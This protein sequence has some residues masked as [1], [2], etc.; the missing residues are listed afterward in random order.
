[1][2]RYLC[3][4]LALFTMETQAQL[5]LKNGTIDTAMP[6]MAATALA[7]PA[8]MKAPDG[9]ICQLVQFSQT[10]GE[11]ERSAIE[12]LGGEIIGYVP[13]DA[14]IVFISNSD[15]FKLPL[16][17]RVQW[18]GPCLPAYKISAKLQNRPDADEV[19]VTI[20][21]F[22]P[23]YLNTVKALANQYGRVTSSGAS[24]ARATVRARLPAS[25]IQI[26]AEQ[27]EV[28]WIEEYT[29]LHFTNNMA[30]EEPRL[31]VKTVWNT[32]GLTGKG[33]IVA[34]ADSGLDVGDRATIHPD[35]AGRIRY[36]H[37]I[38][39]GDD[40]KDYSGH[41]THVAGSVLGSGAAYSNRFYRGV[42]YEAELV[43]QAMGD[44]NGSPNIMIPDPFN[45]LFYEAYTNSARIQQASW[46]ADENGLYS[47]LSR[48]VDEF[49][50]DHDDLLI[51]FAAG[52]AGID[53]NQDG[54]IDQQSVGSPASAKNCLAVGASESGR[55]AGSEGVTS[56]IYGI[57]W[58]SRYPAMPITEDWRST[59]WDNQNQGMAAFSSRGP[60]QDG[61]IKPEV[62]APGTDIIS[63]R[64]QVDGAS[65]APIAGDAGQWYQSA[66]G[67]SMATPLVSGVAALARQYFR[68]YHD[69]STPSS[70]LMKAA[71]INGTVSLFPG[72]YGTDDFQEIPNPT[73]NNIEGWG[74]I[75]A[76]NTFFPANKE[77]IFWDR[78]RLQTGESHHFAL[79]VAD[80]NGIS[81]TV[82]WT[83]PPASLLSARQLVN[84]LD[85]TLT[86]PSGK[87]Y[88]PNGL[89][90]ADH[91]NNVEQIDLPSNERGTWTVA[92]AGTSI[93]EGPQPY[94]LFSTF[95]G[96][97]TPSFELTSAWHH[98]SVITEQ[99]PPQIQASLTTGGKELAAIATAWRL[100]DGKWVYEP[101]TETGKNG[102]NTLYSCELPAYQVGD[103][104]NYY[105]YA[106]S[107]DMQLVNS[108]TNQ[109]RVESLTTYVN[110]TGSQTW[111]YTTPE[112]AWTNLN[113]A[114]EA[115]APNSEI[116]VAS[117]TWPCPGEITDGVAI[118]ALQGPAETII[119]AALQPL[120]LTSG[121]TAS[122]FTVSGGRSTRNGG[123]VYLSDGVLTNCWILNNTTSGDGGGIYQARG[124]ITHCRIEHNKATGS[125][126]GVC[127][128]S[129]TLE[130][131]LIC[132]NET[133]IDGGGV[134]AHG[135]TIQNCTLANNQADEHG[136]GIDFGGI[137]E[138]ENCIAVANRA[139]NDGDNWYM[140]A[141]V[142]ISYTCTT[143][144]VAGQGNIALDPLFVDP[145]NGDYHL[146]SSY[147][148]FTTNCWVYDA[149]DSPC[150]DFG[151]PL[152]DATKETTGIRLNMGAYGNTPEA[153]NSA[154]NKA[155]LV[156]QSKQ[157]TTDP[158]LGLYEFPLNSEVTISLLENP[159]TTGT[160]QYQFSAWTTDSGYDLSTN[161]LS[162]LTVTLTNN[163]LVHALYDSFYQVSVSAGAN[164]SIA[165]SNGWHQ[166]GSDLTIT[167][168]PDRYYQFDQWSGDRS[169]TN[170]PCAITVFG[171]LKIAAGFTPAYTAD[172]VPQSWLGRYGW[173][174]AFESAAQSDQDGDGTATWCEYLAGTDPT[175]K[176]SVLKLKLELTPSV[177]QL[178]WDAQAHRYYT[179]YYSDNLLNG[180]TNVLCEYYSSFPMS[181]T[182]PDTE[183]S[184]KSNMFYR[185]EVKIEQAD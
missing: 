118:V 45:L 174:H 47:S 162:S 151:N 9:Q 65:W 103:Q 144:L 122:G 91:I 185:I 62:V 22:K 120:E 46:G 170:N 2:S 19:E 86:A 101:M 116:F 161:N 36:A 108:A 38:V 147:G 173:T 71:L 127:I 117:G 126:G 23:A 76:E 31:N 72:Q 35:F 32:H 138:I 125:G 64:S 70:A 98:P 177:N 178:R 113:E 68:E 7:M 183:H 107:Y 39:S 4:A 75:N 92:I 156:V 59:P 58:P 157:G 184:D 25:A 77:N 133:G 124:L 145:E 44:T 114:V 123:G 48:D 158:A 61:R 142:N 10:P 171:P 49:T 149:A 52:N 57:S 105:V 89:L 128:Q 137:E 93:P 168:L 33:E 95:N 69:V 159:L 153:S 8:A 139:T 96:D 87:I 176:S 85:L 115:A 134:E 99:M 94:A 21:I 67:T 3:F 40:W 29:P 129:G 121:S 60:C 152:N 82:V 20:S 83:D 73:G 14:W 26:L 140:R 167:A 5:H 102:Q 100:N 148:H 27:A 43:M 17:D 166:A 50:W 143:P 34:V 51:V 78:N 1:M 109:F 130:R 13:D 160:T 55:Q 90:H 11:A 66:N 18:T 135:G 131:S 154:V 37:S 12:Q 54:I 42:A 24:R 155:R 112:T 84:D 163:L 169:A 182:F 15:S 119:N 110:R 88:Y 97:T 181:L 175:N 165:F 80:T 6:Q 79:N 106:F 81:I 104:L 172:G 179:V 164:G 150:I 146:Q 41:G 132:H 53:A 30:V 16:I 136:G 141:P 28:E 63:C 74:Q 56:S 180:I 111:P